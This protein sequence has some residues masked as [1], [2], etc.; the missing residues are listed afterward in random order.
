MKKLLS[1]I[2]LFLLSF[3]VAYA[4]NSFSYPTTFNLKVG[5]H[6]EIA[7]LRNAMIEFKEIKSATGSCETSMTP[8]PLGN[9]ASGANPRKSAVFSVRIPA[10]CVETM[11]YPSQTNCTIPAYMETFTVVE[12]NY[13]VAQSLKITVTDIREASA[14]FGVAITNGEENG[15]EIKPLPPVSSEP[16]KPGV[17]GGGSVSGS[18]EIST[19]IGTKTIE[20]KGIVYPIGPITICPMGGEDCTVCASGSCKEKTIPYTEGTATTPGVRT[21]NVSGDAEITSVN[22]VTIG[23]STPAY[24]VETVKKARLLFLFPISV[25]VDYSVEA[26]TGTTLS[27]EKPWWSFLAW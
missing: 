25:K 3:S 19:P 11:S 24:K 18:G 7:N 17:T 6:A 2:P 27:V 9:P 23:T 10:L 26:K 13:V 16:A 14:N 5:D 15:L 20:G 4:H 1:F 8:C 12:G 22:N 21:V